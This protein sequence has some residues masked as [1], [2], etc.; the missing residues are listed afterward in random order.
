MDSTYFGH[1]TFGIPRHIWCV[2]FSPE[3]CPS[4]HKTFAVQLKD[5]KHCPIAGHSAPIVLFVPL[6]QKTLPVKIKEMKEKLQV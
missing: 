2:R 4:P 1:A 3:Q 5:V 6:G